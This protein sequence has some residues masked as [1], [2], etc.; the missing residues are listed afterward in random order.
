MRRV[1]PLAFALLFAAGAGS[2]EARPGE[3]VRVERPRYVPK[4]RI[5][6]C[7]QTGNDD[8]KMLCI[9]NPP[10]KRDEIIH[11]MD[12]RGGVVAQA[13]VVRTAPSTQPM[14]RSEQASDVYYRTTLSGSTA[15]TSW[16]IGLMGVEV[17]RERGKMDGGSDIELPPAARRKE[18]VFIAVDRDGS[19]HHDMIVTSRPCELPPPP[20]TS[21]Q[22]EAQCLAYW[23]LE[24]ASWRLVNEDVLYNCR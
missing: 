17:D 2:A 1:V 18:Q 21:G 20:G 13:R 19:G 14:C 11:V 9:G 16:M 22:G 24:G 15:P 3:I 10:P 12:F 23:L 5:R 7:V 8:S 4:E 6:V